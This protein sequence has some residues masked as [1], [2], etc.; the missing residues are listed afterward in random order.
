MAKDRAIVQCRTSFVGNG[1]GAH[2]G[3]LFYS[4]DP[5]VLEHPQ[6]FAAPKVRGSI[7]DTP[8]VEQATAAPGE[9]RGV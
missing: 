2:E 8:I 4:D 9:K 3:E 6:Y 7:V 5:L 1:F